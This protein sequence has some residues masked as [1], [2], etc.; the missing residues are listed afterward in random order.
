M[1][2]ATGSLP[3]EVA[4]AFGTVGLAEGDRVVCVCERYES[5]PHVR[6]VDECT[7]DQIIRWALSREKRC[8]S[9]L[10]AER[11]LRRLE[12][13]ARQIAP[14]SMLKPK[15]IIRPLQQ[16]ALQCTDGQARLHA[17][18]CWDNISPQG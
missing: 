2:H 7:V 12:D 4:E 10:V 9:S 14:F 16:L 1:L 17:A 18:C 13:E 15:L 11:V 3:P 5:G 8:A 6:S